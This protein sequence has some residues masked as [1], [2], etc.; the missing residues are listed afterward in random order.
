MAAQAQKRT[1]L[2]V[3]LEKE[4]YT[5][6]IYTQ[7]Y[8]ALRKRANVTEVEEPRATLAALS[9]NPRPDAVIL[10]DPAI[11]NSTSKHNKLLTKLIEYAH[12]GGT[13]ILGM[14]YSN[15]I[16][17]MRFRPFL[18][19]WGVPWDRGSYFRTTTVLNPAGVPAPLDKSALLPSVSMK[20]VH[21]KGAPREHAVYLPTAESCIQ[22]HVFAPDRLTGEQAEESPAVLARVGQ[23]YLGYV[24]D[25]NAEQGSTRLILE[26][27]GVKIQ[28]GDLGQRTISTGL[29][30]KP[31]GTMEPIIETEE[32]VPLPLPSPPPR[33]PRLRDTE[34]AA[35]AE[36]R[37]RVRERKRTRADALKNKVRVF[38][39]LASRIAVHGRLGKRLVQEGRVA[40]GRG[41]VS[42]CR[43]ARWLAARLSLQSCCLPPQAGTVG[44][45]GQ[46]GNACSH[47]RPEA[48][49]GAVSQS[50]RTKGDWT[51]G[52]CLRR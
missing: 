31:D 38:L 34:V 21:V 8:S 4:S 5:D 40:G 12:S 46:R 9:T 48:H 23:G 49:Q 36:A 43:I 16:K 51:E 18:T 42:C 20:S 10:S 24:G 13:V 1:I 30:M 3:S 25:V 19:R 52:S 22:S 17:P 28:P 7:L 27:C 50:A 15:H 6:E 44:A 26:M 39:C 14:Q 29:S 41:K 45:G 35:R 32:E 2:V 11:A 47:A 37:R 33:A